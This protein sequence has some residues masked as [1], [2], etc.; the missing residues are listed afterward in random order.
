MNAITTAQLLTQIVSNYRN[1]VI[2]TESAIQQFP[3]NNPQRNAALMAE[4]QAAVLVE[5]YG[6]E[7]EAGISYFNVWD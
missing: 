7:K 4:A 3:V 2:A 5:L 1:A 6:L